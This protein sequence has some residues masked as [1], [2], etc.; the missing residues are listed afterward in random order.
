MKYLK[1]DLIC[2]QIKD[3]KFTYFLFVLFFFFLLETSNPSPATQ[4]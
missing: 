1:F 3:L 4:F 2:V